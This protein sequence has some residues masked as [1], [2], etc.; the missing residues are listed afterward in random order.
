MHHTITDGEGGVQMALQ[1]LDFDRD[2]AD[3]AGR[4]PGRDRR[5]P[6]AAAAVG[7]ST[8]VRDLVAG[9][10]RL[11]LGVA[12]QVHELLA[13]PP[14]IPTASAATAETIRGVVQQLSDVDRARSPLWTERSLRRHVE[15][16][17]APFRATKDAAKRLGGTLNTAFLTAAADAAGAVPRATSARPSSTCARRWRSAPA[18]RPPTATPSRW[19]G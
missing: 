10:F 15:V 16:V 2:A 4:R 13:D 8:T 6:A 7:R 17:R 1:Y 14:S 19:P 11:P 12:R 18:R 9:G 5:D 3:P